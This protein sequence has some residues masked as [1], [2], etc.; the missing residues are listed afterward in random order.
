[1]EKNETKICDIPLSK[2]MEAAAQEYYNRTGTRPTSVDFEWAV[3]MGSK[4]V[5]IKSDMHVKHP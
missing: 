2:L 1:M 3:S 5:C 4:A